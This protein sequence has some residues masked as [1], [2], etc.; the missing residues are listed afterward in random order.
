MKKQ[1]FWSAAL[2][3]MNDSSRYYPKVGNLV[4]SAWWPFLE[5][6][7]AKH[8]IWS[9]SHSISHVRVYCQ[10]TSAKAN[11]S[12]KLSLYLS[13]LEDKRSFSPKG[14]LK[15][16]V[17]FNKS[18]VRPRD[19]CNCPAKTRALKEVSELQ[20]FPIFLSVKWIYIRRG[21]DGV[22]EHCSLSNPLTKLQRWC[23]T[24]KSKG[25]NT[26]SNLYFYK[27]KTVVHKI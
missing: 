18:K 5:K 17:N 12:S 2:Y 11:C 16:A 9:F 1:C 23:N 7:I 6:K 27:Q 19:A 10:V 14:H 25:L 3:W 26:V 15:P 4:H 20:T 8:F 22:K 24:Q 13:S 21:H